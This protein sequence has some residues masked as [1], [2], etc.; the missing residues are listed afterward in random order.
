MMLKFI[1]TDINQ[2]KDDNL[3]DLITS[4]MKKKSNERL[5]WEEYVNHSFFKN[6]SESDNIDSYKYEELAHIEIGYQ[7]ITNIIILKNN[8]VLCREKR[9]S[10]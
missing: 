1:N 10:L 2:I 9:N 3:K 4:L 5:S 6:N 8:F 7:E